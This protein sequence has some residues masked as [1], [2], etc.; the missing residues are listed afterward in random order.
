MATIGAT[1]GQNRFGYYMVPACALVGGWLA[2]RILEIGDRTEGV[3]S[4]VTLRLR[5]SA[6]VFVVAAMIAPS[7]PS[8]LLFLPRTGMFTAYWQQALDWLREHSDP[9]FGTDYYYYAPYGPIPVKAEYTVM[10]WWD[11]GYYLIQRA[12]RVPVSNP[13]QERAP[14]AA[15]FYTETDESRAVALLMRER[16]RYV[17]ADWELPF[18]LAPDGS[19]A[20][21]GQSIDHRTVVRFV[22]QPD[23][24]PSL[25]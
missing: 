19:I 14:N 11:Q 12:R 21:H 25:R 15:R 7:L 16:S 22:E 18:R 8:R 2:H 20:E 5:Q 23:R 24:R 17:L 6:G 9:P 4:R 13:T 10:N 3:R 1:V